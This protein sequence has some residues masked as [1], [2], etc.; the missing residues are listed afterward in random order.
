MP[1]PSVFEDN[2]MKNVHT[3]T[4]NSDKFLN[5]SK[6]S[7]VEPSMRQPRPNIV[8]PST[9]KV[10][11]NSLIGKIKKIPPSAIEVRH[12]SNTTENE[13]FEIITQ[14]EMDEEEFIEE[15]LEITRTDQ[16]DTLNFSEFCRLCVT[17]PSDLIPIFD[18]NGDFCKETE[19]IKLMPHGTITCNDGLPQ[20]ACPECLHKLQSCMDTIDGFVKNQSLYSME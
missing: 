9:T 4:K 11:V 18:E 15:D 3:V 12:T 13:Y 1:L 19:C 20:Y 8:R 14:D 17:C 10:D 2:L 5:Y 7:I 16:D 6:H